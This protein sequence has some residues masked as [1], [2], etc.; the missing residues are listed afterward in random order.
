M[1]VLAVFY[2]RYH[3]RYHLSVLKTIGF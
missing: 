2:V 3:C 1:P